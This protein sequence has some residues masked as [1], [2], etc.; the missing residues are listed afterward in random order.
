MIALTFSGSQDVPRAPES[1]FENCCYKIF[2]RPEMQEEN[3]NNNKNTENKKQ[4][5][6]SESNH[7]RIYNKM[8]MDYINTPGKGQNCET[9]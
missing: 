4:N 3:P 1:N 6:T 5:S 7:N 8:S 2:D 9:K